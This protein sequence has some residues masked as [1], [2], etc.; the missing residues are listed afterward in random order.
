[1][2]R[3]GHRHMRTQAANPPRKRR[4]EI[5]L[6]QTARMWGEFLANGDDRR[7]GGI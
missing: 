2:I 4:L 7:T 3:A 1:M 6:L 5:C